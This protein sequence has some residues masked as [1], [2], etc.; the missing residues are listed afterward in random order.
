MTIQVTGKNLDVGEAMREYVR[1]RIA[2]TFDKYLGRE[3]SGHVRIEKEHGQFRTACLVHLWQG[4]SLEAEGRAPDPHQSADL[5]C[6]RLDKRL[7]RYKRR[8]N[9]HSGERAAKSEGT[10]AATYVIQASPETEDEAEH[11]DN[12]VIIAES[13]QLVHDM[14]VSDAVM[15][16]DLSDRPVVVFRNAGSGAVNL[17]Y[18]RSD[19]HIGWIDLA[20]KKA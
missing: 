11:G 10:A 14:T 2:H 16:M 5:A 13:E 17:V 9:D 6:E 7:R 4:M 19:G 12:P 3:P 8:L 18:R 20:G 15:Q 1:D